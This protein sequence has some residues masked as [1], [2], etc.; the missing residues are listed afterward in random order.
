MKRAVLFS[1]VVLALVL[2]GCTDTG[3]LRIDNE[4]NND[5]WVSIDGGSQV[6]LQ[7]GYYYTKDWELAVS[8]FG[9]E[10]KDVNV[11]FNGYHL[12]SGHTIRTVKPGSTTRFNIYADGGGI[13]INNNSSAFTITHVYISPSSSSTWGDD[14]LGYDTIGPQSWRSW[15]VTSGYWDIK[16]RDNWGDEFTN[17]NNYIYLDQTTQFNYTGF[18]RT[19]DPEGDKVRN[20]ANYSEELQDY[21][22]EAK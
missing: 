12:F 17:F 7:S 8:I 9:N 20:A 19:D 11:S 21:R 14:Q 2:V 4:T 6:T 22:I 18:L 3:T 16:V 15:T 1:I 10:E 5:A 13:R